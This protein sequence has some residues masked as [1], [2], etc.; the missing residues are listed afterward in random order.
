M[1]GFAAYTHHRHN[2]DYRRVLIGQDLYPALLD[3]SNKESLS[4][5]NNKSLGD[6]NI[7]TLSSDQICDL[8]CDIS[9]ESLQDRSN[10]DTTSKCLAT[11]QAGWFILSCISRGA[12]RLA[13]TELEISTLAFALVSLVLYVLWWDKPQSV[14]VQQLIHP[15]W[16][17]PETPFEGERKFPHTLRVMI[18]PVWVTQQRHWYSE[19]RVPSMWWST[20]F[21]I[22]GG[23]ERLLLPSAVIGLFFGLVHCI[24]WEFYFPSMLERTLWRV[25]AV[26]VGIGPALVL[27]SIA[28][29]GRLVTIPTV[30]K[31]TWV[32]LFSFVT[33]ILP[34]VAFIAARGGL[35][36]V[37][38]MALRAIPLSAYQTVPWLSYIP[39]L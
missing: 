27:L 25:C 18:T 30:S 24:A 23:R 6:T 26:A 7:P 32:V 9:I 13:L 1:G 34:Y 3:T 31:S 28:I 2:S 19:D 5:T 20:S 17:L 39:H 37:S 4:T 15:S 35:L 10:G 36:V 11:L 8:I 21:H 33:I 12:N 14:D 16:K 22:R 38:L 29:S